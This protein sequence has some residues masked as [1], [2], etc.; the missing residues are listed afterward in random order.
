VLNQG[1]ANTLAPSSW[2]DEQSIEFRVTV[3]TREDGG[4]SFNAASHFRDE[5]SAGVDLVKRQ[6]DCVWIRQQ[7]LTISG[8]VERGSPLK[9]FES[10]LLRRNGDSNV[11]LSHAIQRGLG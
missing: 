6:I 4:K 8:I 9:G 11:D 10:L 5:Y 2:L 3:L 7:S 1:S